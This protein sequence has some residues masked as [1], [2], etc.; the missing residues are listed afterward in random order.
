MNQATVAR[1]LADLLNAW[2]VEH[3]FGTAGDTILHFLASLHGHPT[4]FIQLRNEETAAYAASA[5]A[6]L[7][8]KLGVV[9]ADGGPGT[10]RLVNGLAD[11]ISDRAPVLAITGQVET[12]FLGTGYK[13][14]INQQQLLGAVTIRSENLGVP[15]SLVAVA[16]ALVRTALAQGG[17]VHLSIPKDFWQQHV[18]SALVKTEPF[19]SEMPQS[20]DSVIA[21][22]AE[23]VSALQ[24][25]MVLVGRG[26]SHAVPE[27]LALAERLGAGIAYTLPMVGAM[28]EHPLVVGGIGEGGSEVSVELLRQCDGVVRV[29]ATYWPPEFTSDEKRFLSLD[30][31]PAQV[32]MGISADFG[33]V[34]DTKAVLAKLLSQLGDTAVHGP[35]IDQ[36]RNEAAEWHQRLE[37]ELE[38]A[39]PNHPG[40]AVRILAE[41]AAADV[42]I[43]LDVG[44]HVL[45]FSR[46]FQGKGQKVLVSG[47]WR[48]MGFSLGASIAAQLAKPQSQVL[49]VVG[50]GGFSMLM[51][52]FVSAV[53][54]GLPI[55]YILMNNKSYA[56]EA[57]AMAASGLEPCG[58]QL[59][60]I[61]FDQVSQACG[62]L[63]YRISPPELQ[64]VLDTAKNAIKP[65]L[66]DLQ[67]DPIKFPTA[68]L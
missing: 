38:E 10:G 22:G 25:P 47:R 44:D 39:S 33:L 31:V 36:V 2:G 66:I 15:T 24:K 4:R 3:V 59:G 64:S 68:R 67:V 52:D 8:G 65:V 49:T 62:G 27:V 51:G 20:A 50:D 11:A 23:W 54:L 63:G 41:H 37:R 45:W 60:D 17:P 40:K 42:V 46:F 7:T 34:G 32:S 12:T 55:T 9:V 57:N 29:G 1:A 19:L 53:E 6:K 61:R 13:Q 43:C 5:Y 35:W 56:L 14:Y 16:S 58:V 26:A 48:G 21:K 28:P 18:G 30:A